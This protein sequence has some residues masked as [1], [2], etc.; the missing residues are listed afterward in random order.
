MGKM[1]YLVIHTSDSPYNREVTPDD[2][3]T[4]HLGALKNSDGTY[5]FFGKTYTKAELDGW[6]LQLPSGKVLNALDT[7]GRGWAQVGYSDLIQRTGELI[8]L[9][10]YND[11]EVIDSAEITNGAAGYNSQSR[12]VCLAG[13]WSEDGTIKD[14]HQDG[15]YLEASVLYTP[16]Q[17]ATLVSYIALQRS[18]VPDVSVIGHNQL[19]TKTCPNFDVQVFLQTNCQ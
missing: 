12:H 1:K 18:M 13:G 4:W 11:D 15:V 7:D 10:P 5:T 19:S 14:G 17:I 2:I 9:V 6:T 16:E 8:N 3:A